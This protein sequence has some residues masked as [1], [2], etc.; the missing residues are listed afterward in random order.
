MMSQDISIGLS[1]DWNVFHQTTTQTTAIFEGSGH[2]H[3]NQ[4]RI[5]NV[6][7]MLVTAHYYLQ[8]GEML[9]YIGLGAGAYYIGNRNEV[10][11]YA[12]EDNNWHF[13]VAP[14]LG[15]LIPAG[16]DFFMQI[17]A[18]YHYPFEANSIKRPYVTANI[19]FLW[20]AD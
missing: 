20:A 2:V 10:G 15:V 1:L 14:E 3:G 11:I 19:G 9:P 7:P 4:N 18:K 17:G 12:F 5:V 8:T 13:G 16:F 6:F